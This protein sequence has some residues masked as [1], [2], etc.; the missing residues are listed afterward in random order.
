[1]HV[2]GW[3][4]KILFFSICV[5][6]THVILTYWLSLLCSHILIF[7]SCLPHKSFISFCRWR[8][9]H[10]TGRTAPWF[11]LHTLMTPLKSNFSIPWTRKA[12]RYGR[13]SMT[14]VSVVWIHTITSGQP[15]KTL[16]EKTEKETAYFIIEVIGWIN[17]R[18]TWTH[19]LALIITWLFHREWWMA[20]PS[21]AFQEECKKRGPVWRH[22]FLPNYGAQ[23]HVLRIQ[24]HPSLHPHHDY[25]HLQLLSATRCWWGPTS[26]ICHIIEAPS[27][28][29]IFLWG[30]SVGKVNIT[31]NHLQMLFLFKLWGMILSFPE[32]IRKQ[33]SKTEIKNISRHFLIWASLIKSN[34]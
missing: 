21:Q 18:H 9:F 28:N 27:N 19:T 34:H 15:R 4:I 30:L 3:H 2:I 24:H 10:L 1:M 31:I 7:C 26:Q 14:P 13:S 33:Y 17:K 12:M 20:Y 11:S 8:T 25:R 16:R 22:H 6:F 23:T 29:L 32:K 5:I